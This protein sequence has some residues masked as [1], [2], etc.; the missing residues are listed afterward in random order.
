MASRVIYLA[1][2]H[3]FLQALWTVVICILL[4]AAELFV[5]AL[6]VAPRWVAGKLLALLHA[7]ARRARRHRRPATPRREPARASREGA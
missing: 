2:I 4:V 6:I 5:V 1:S 3:G 7:P